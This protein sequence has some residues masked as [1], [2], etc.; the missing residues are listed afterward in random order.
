MTGRERVK[1]LVQAT[2]Y[3]VQNKIEGAFIE[4]GVWRGGSVMAMALAL[5]D[6]GEVREIY[7]YDTF[8]G[9]VAPS[10]A[11]GDA[12]QKLFSEL[13]ISA[14]SSRWLFCPVE[15]VKGNL[16]RTGYP[17][18]RLHFI[19]GKVEETIPKTIP[20][21]I[22]LLRLDIDFY[23]ST[24]HALIHLFP[25]VS[26][27]GVVI[28]DDYGRWPGVKKAVDEYIADNNLNLILHDLDRQARLSL[29]SPD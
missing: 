24:K 17:S 22:A 18:E 20:E 13:R 19:K 14:D 26:P 4:C 16:S 8:S 10:P 11:D 7:L 5:K 29:K 25:R 1:A 6:M 15:E 12:A 28:F 21:K 2:A 3:V 23:A 9:M 27:K